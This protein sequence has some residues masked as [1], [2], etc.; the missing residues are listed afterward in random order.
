MSDG[1]E[2]IGEESSSSLNPNLAQEQTATKKGWRPQDEF[3]GN[4]EDWVDAKEFLAREP[5]LKEVRDLKKHIRTQRE[6]MDRDMQVISSQFSQVSEMAYRKAIDDLQAQRDL[7]IQDQDVQTVRVLDK[8]IDETALEHAKTQAQTRPQVR[9]RELQNEEMEQWRANNVWFDNDKELQDD[10]VTLGLGYAAK[11]PNKTQADMLQHV[12]D[13][14]KKMHP[15]KFKS[16]QRTQ[17]E[18]NK[19]EGRSSSPVLG[20]GKSKLSWSELDD[21]ERQVG[22]TLIKRGA[23]KELAAKNKRTEQ[24]EFLAQLAERKAK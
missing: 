18:D 1:I 9:Q 4:P 10:A 8:K 23:L 15:D 5:L 6:Q 20:K 22:R 2:I 17:V 21:D 19:V 14:I 16:N 13:K 11:N 3:Q 24:D 7:A 12:E